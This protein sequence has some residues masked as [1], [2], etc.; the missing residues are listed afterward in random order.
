MGAW[1]YGVRQDDFVCDVIGVFEDLLKAG[2]SVREATEDVRSQFAA[3]TNDADDGPLFW[4]ALA[5][6][7]WTYGEMDPQIVNRV[8]E[9]LDSGRSLAAWTEDQ[10][11]LARRRAALEK[12]INT[13]G[14]PNPRP[15]KLP[16]TIVRAPKFRA[17]EC[18][19]IRVSNGQYAAALVLAADHS[20]AEYGTN[21]IGLLD[22]LSSEKPTI[23]VFRKRKWLGVNHDSAPN[24]MD[25]AWYYHMG[26]RAVKDRLAIVGE[27]EILGS[28]PKDSN[29]YRRWTGIGEQAIPRR[30]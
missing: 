18:L 30:E 8:K 15:K 3:E 16:K 10:H 25:I 20:N 26:F 13:I 14:Q 1:G 6:M 19:S 12:F 11:G 2:K 24:T 5:D 9:D 4:M 29:I 22:Y 17:G 28:D 23:E 7:Q 21:L 27:V